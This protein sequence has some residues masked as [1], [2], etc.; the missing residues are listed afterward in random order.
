MGS[1][2]AEPDAWGLDA[3]DVNPATPWK[4]L[5]EYRIEEDAAMGCPRC[6]A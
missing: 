4:A 6:V 2:V 5:T 1:V 3:R